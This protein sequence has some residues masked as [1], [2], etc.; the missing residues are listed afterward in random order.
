LLRESFRLHQ[1]ELAGS[2]DLVLVAKPS[3]ARRSWA[4]V[5]SDFLAALTAANLLKEAT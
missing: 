3:I 1:H 2:T 5:E 4:E